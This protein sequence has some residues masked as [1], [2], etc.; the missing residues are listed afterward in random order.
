MAE[1]SGTF[2]RQDVPAVPPRLFASP[3][4]V[5]GNLAQ[6]GPFLRW[7]T[8]RGI[9]ENASEIAFSVSD[10]HTARN[11]FCICCD[12]GQF[13]GQHEKL[14]LARSIPQFNTGKT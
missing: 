11:I 2:A 14:C 13:R 8:A 5:R 3:H 10:N 1:C 9:F 12:P 6:A 7:A 4:F